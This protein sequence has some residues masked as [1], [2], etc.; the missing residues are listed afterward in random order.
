MAHSSQ[1]EKK[2]P[3]VAAEHPLTPHILSLI[4]KPPCTQ[5]ITLLAKASHEEI[6]QRYEM[7]TI[8]H[9]KIVEA[10]EKERDKLFLELKE[11]ANNNA[12]QKERVINLTFELET[13][14]KIDPED[15]FVPVLL[16]APP[17]Q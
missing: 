12:L 5:T 8:E 17:G 3:K 4:Q 13:L 7:L 16:D 1:K 6:T 10:Y 2:Q 15:L 11:L 14:L 9:E